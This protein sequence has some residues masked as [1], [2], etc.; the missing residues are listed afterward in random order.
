MNSLGKVVA[1]RPRRQ[2]GGCG[3][4]VTFQQRAYYDALHE[5]LT[6][7]L[8]ADPEVNLSN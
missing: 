6:V 1:T 8:G 4:P 2:S 5:S 3:V 7:L